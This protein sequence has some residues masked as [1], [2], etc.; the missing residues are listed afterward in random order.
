[1]EKFANKSK[2]SNAFLTN[3]CVKEE[4][5]REIRNYLQTIEKENTT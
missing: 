1:M 4:N 2:F 3:H 5:K